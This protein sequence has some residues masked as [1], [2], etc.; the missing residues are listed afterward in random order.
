MADVGLSLAFWPIATITVVAAL[1]VVGLKNLLHAALALVLSFVGVAAAYVTLRADFVAA[2]QIL[3]YAG[4]I[5]VLILFGILLTGNVIVGN[6][7]NRFRLPAMAVALSLAGV[8]VW[9][10]SVR[11]VWPVSVQV[12][13][14]GLTPVA[15]IADALFNRFLLPFE[16]ASVM[17]LAAMVGAI[18]LTRQD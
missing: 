12:L 9:V 17:L 5:A 16:V 10:V 7:P 1:A 2:V 14:D 18:V 11:T 3:I 15:V 13:P 4:A 6:P 8:L